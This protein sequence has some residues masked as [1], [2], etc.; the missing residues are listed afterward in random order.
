MHEY[1]KLR[2]IQN[3]RLI[4]ILPAD[5]IESPYK[6]NKLFRGISVRVSEHVFDCQLILGKRYFI[7]GYY[8]YSPQKQDFEAWNLK[9][10]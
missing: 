8:N 2:H 10:I 6:L 4:R 7:I 3:C 1:P 5:S 9:A